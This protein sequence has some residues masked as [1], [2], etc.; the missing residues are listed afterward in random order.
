M[1]A[2]FATLLLALAACSDTARPQPVRMTEADLP[3]PRAEKRDP[4][5][6]TD[7]GPENPDEF[8]LNGRVLELPTQDQA[9]Q[10]AER[11]I[12]RAN[13]EAELQRLRQEI[14]REQ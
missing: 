12:T 8:A 2:F 9:D 3:E 13:F 4:A 5:V 10:I 11:R 14:E 1:K 7:P 6:L